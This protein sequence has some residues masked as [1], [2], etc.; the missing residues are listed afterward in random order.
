MFFEQPEIIKIL[1]KEYS[2]SDADIEA[3]NY[4]YTNTIVKLII[5]E[6]LLYIEQHKL[7]EQKELEQIL[8]SSK[9]TRGQLETE[10]NLVRFVTVLPGKYPK[11]LTLLKDKIQQIDESLAHDMIA[12]LSEEAGRRI[13]EIINNDLDRINIFSEKFLKGLEK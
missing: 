7:P 5:E 13:L 9:A 8:Q 10:I 4:A 2:W 12:N 6:S 3:M 11:L 1:Q